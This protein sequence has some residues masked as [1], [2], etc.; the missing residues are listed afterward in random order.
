MK[1]IALVVLVVLLSGGSFLRA[2]DGKDGVS[3][4][5][6]GNVVQRLTKTAKAKYQGDDPN[7]TYEKILKGMTYTQKTAEFLPQV[8]SARRPVELAASVANQLLQPLLESDPKVVRR[9]MSTVAGVHR[10]YVRYLPPPKYSR[11]QLKSLAFPDNMEK[12]PPKKALEIVERIQALRQRKLLKDQQ[13]AFRN[14]AAA[15]LEETFF[16]LML[17]ADLDR[18]DKALFAQLRSNERARKWG[19][20]NIL[21]ALR[22]EAEGMNGVRAKWWFGRIK[23][24]ANDRKFHRHSFIKPGQLKLIAADNSE[25]DKEEILVGY[26]LYKTAAAL[27][28][29]A[30]EGKFKHPSA[31]DIE[32]AI[33]KRKKKNK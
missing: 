8:L 25:F 18:Y 10:R 3:K 31:K 22:Q 17:K 2:A 15:A 13:I 16:Q 6:L 30:G 32:T 33:K 14:R 19:F 9:L 12:L 26:E 29:P 21:Y 1:R 28:K 27:A 4:E 11:S 24:Y 5:E 20:M 7:D 23:D